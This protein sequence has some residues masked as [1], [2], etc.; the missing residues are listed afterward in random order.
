MSNMPAQIQKQSE[1]IR[2]LYETLNAPPED[3]TPTQEVQGQTPPE[4]V[5]NPPQ[6]QT[7]PHTENWELRFKQLNSTVHANNSRY[8]N[9]IRELETLLSNVMVQRAPSP[10][11]TP[12]APPPKLISEAEVTEYG[13]AIEVMRKAAREEIAGRDTIIERLQQEL[14][15]IRGQLQTNVVPNVN[16]LA[17]ANAEQRERAFWTDLKSLASNWEIINAKDEFKHWLLQTDPFTGFQRNV[18]LQDAREKGDATRAAAFFTEWSK[19]N[20]EAPT[21]TPAA[22]VPTPDLTKHIAPGRARSTTTGQTNT[23]VVYTRDDIAKFYDDVRAGR[24]R[25]RDQERARIENDIFAASREGRL[26][27]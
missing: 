9:R 17:K 25:G 12:P 23:P 18:M 1:D 16:H 21:P 5:Q 22:P 6:G 8:E 15:D 13:D 27:N 2:K 7:P 20:P 10:A 14:A 4:E 24:Y 26:Q 11:P 3:Q 19:M